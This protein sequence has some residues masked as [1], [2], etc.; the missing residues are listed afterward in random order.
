MNDA[1]EIS[2]G[3]DFAYS[4]GQLPLQLAKHVLDWPVRRPVG[5]AEQ[6]A[7]PVS[8][9]RVHNDGA[10]V[11]IEVVVH[12]GAD[13]AAGSRGRQGLHHGADESVVRISCGARGL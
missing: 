11:S 6:V 10:F 8:P 4:V 3:A 2:L 12:D 13:R 5:G 1:Y 9:D 7:M